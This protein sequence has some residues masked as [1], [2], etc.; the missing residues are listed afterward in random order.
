M[1][2]AIDDLRY[3]SKYGYQDPWAEATKNVTDS[4]LAYGQSKLK[5][6]VDC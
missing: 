4:L 5:R 2:S 6:D 3:I 1:A